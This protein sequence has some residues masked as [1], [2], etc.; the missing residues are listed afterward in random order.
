MVKI[1]PCPISPNINPNSYGNVTIVNKAGFTSP[2][3][4]TPYV[5]TI[6]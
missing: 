2:Y 3:L 4:G 1:P 6:Y 5:S